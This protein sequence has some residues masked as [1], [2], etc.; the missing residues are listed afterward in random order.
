MPSEKDTPSEKKTEFL[1]KVVNAMK[2]LKLG[3]DAGAS[4][5]FWGIVVYVWPNE[6]SIPCSPAICARCFAVY[7]HIA[8]STFYTY[9]EE[10][11]NQV[12]TGLLV[13]SISLR[14]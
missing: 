2:L 14:L 13:S 12:L 10:C 4:D 6:S 1:P 8:C 7:L 11:K 9:V 3:A 5:I